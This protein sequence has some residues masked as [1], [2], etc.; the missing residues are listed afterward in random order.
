MGA[1][2]GVII[3]LV[4]VVIEFRILSRKVSYLPD[5]PVRPFQ[6]IRID[7]FRAVG[8]ED[9]LALNAHVGRHAKLHPVS[10]G[11]TNHRIGYAGITRSRVDQ[12]LVP[13]HQARALS[14][15]NDVQRRAVLD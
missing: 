10:A 12:D 7:D 15:Q 8:L 9:P 5:C 6:G 11:R 3:I 14:F 4:R 13:G 2:V 1:P